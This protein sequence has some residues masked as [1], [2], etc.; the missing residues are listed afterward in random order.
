MDSP[1]PGAEG[2]PGTDRPIHLWNP[3]G[4]DPRA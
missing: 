2:A 4:F 1:R 3:A